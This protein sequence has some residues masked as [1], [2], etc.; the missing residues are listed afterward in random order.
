MGRINGW[1]QFVLTAEEYRVLSQ[2]KKMPNQESGAKGGA[3]TRS[4]M[5]PDHYA[6]IGCRGGETTLERHG[7]GFFKTLGKQGGDTTSERHG[8]EHYVQMGKK[9]G[10]RTR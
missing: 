10:A 1:G 8:P 7:S 5:G 6:T 9:G 2:R 3:T 4:R